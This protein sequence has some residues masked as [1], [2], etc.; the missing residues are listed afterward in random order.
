M[1]YSIFKSNN[2]V[3]VETSTGSLVS[4]FPIS[5]SA[6]IVTEKEFKILCSSYTFTCKYSEIS[7]T[8]N[9]TLGIK[10]F[11]EML[12]IAAFGYFPF[13]VDFD[14]VEHTIA[15]VNTEYL[16]FLFKAKAGDV[17]NPIIKNLLISALSGSNDDVIIRISKGLDFDHTFTDGN[18]RDISTNSQLQVAEIGKLGVPVNV[19]CTT[20]P[21]TLREFSTYLKN[22]SV[23]NESSKCL[24]Q[25]KD[26]NNM[27]TIS[28]KSATV[29][30]KIL[31]S[32][33]A[34]E[35]KTI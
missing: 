33:S 7:Q 6:F 9:G 19:I 1:E 34:L 12:G 4:S 31:L 8:N 25:D 22:S 26:N 10:E 3:T 16:A 30:A 27:I 28:F 29:G 2:D 17:I 18:F 24:S 35:Q 32:L 23:V 13:A 21:N 20:N 11:S 15:A 5:S 14:T